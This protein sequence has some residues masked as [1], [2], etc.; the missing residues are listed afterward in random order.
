MKKAARMRR[1]LEIDKMLMEGWSVPIIA[2]TVGLSDRTIH[3]RKAALHKVAVET[4]PLL[5]ELAEL[6]AEFPTP[7]LPP[8][9][10]V[11]DVLE[12]WGPDA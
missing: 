7:A 2:Q 1:D 10:G 5:L 12:P 3:N 4:D 9:G 6:E 11:L 8:M